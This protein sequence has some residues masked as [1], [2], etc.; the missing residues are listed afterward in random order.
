MIRFDGL[1][2]NV[3][4]PKHPPINC[5]FGVLVMEKTVFDILDDNLKSVYNEYKGQLHR[6]LTDIFIGDELKETTLKILEQVFKDGVKNPKGFDEDLAHDKIFELAD[7][8]IE[9]ERENAKE[10]A[11]E[12]MKEDQRDQRRG[13]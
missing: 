3:V 4:F 2:S 8:A 13:S 9:L 5:I 11:L 6:K 1:H 12:Q 7:E 10:K